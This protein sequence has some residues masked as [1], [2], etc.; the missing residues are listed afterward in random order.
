MRGGKALKLPYWNRLTMNM[1]GCNVSSSPNFT[2]YYV[3]VAQ[4]EHSLR[5]FPVYAT[6]TCTL[7]IAGRWN[8]N[9]YYTYYNTYTKHT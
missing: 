9:C 6:V 3:Y 1:Q 5:V 4:L 8:V 7:L 2:R